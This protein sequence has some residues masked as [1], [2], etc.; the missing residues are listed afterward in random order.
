MSLELSMNDFKKNLMSKEKII[1]D[2]KSERDKLIRNQN[3]SLFEGKKEINNNELELAEKTKKEVCVLVIKAAESLIPKNSQKIMSENERNELSYNQCISLYIILE[4]YPKNPTI[5]FNLGFSYLNMK[6]F[7]KA[8]DC[9]SQALSNCQDQKNVHIILHKI[10]ECNVG[11]SNL[12]EAIVNLKNSIS[13]RGDYC[14]SYYLLGKINMYMRNEGEAF[15]Y[16]SNIYSINPDFLDIRQIYNE[17]EKSRKQNLSN[18]KFN[19]W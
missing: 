18:D 17:L 11:L 8:K 4:L 9:F 6:K 15:K 13:I 5:H 7:D 3:F 19:L 10:A 2:L 14:E 16:Y 1:E 12:E